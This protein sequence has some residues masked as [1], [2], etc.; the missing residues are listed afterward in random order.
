VIYYARGI[1]FYAHESGVRDIIFAMYHSLE[2][3]T[4]ASLRAEFDTL[5]FDAF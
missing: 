1:A 2:R 3:K 5:P 4:D